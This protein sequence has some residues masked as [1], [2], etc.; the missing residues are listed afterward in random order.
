MQ[1]LIALLDRLKSATV[2]LQE[3][4]LLKIVENNKDT[5]IDLNLS[6]L[7]Q[8]RN[9]AG[10]SL[11]NYASKEYADFKRTLNPLG[12][13]DLKLEGD[14]HAGFYVEASK[15][16]VVIDSADEKTNELGIKYGED[17]FGLDQKNQAIFQAEIL[18]ETI[19]YYEELMGV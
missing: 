8:G 17:I 6:Q 13:I 7:M 9:S 11:G 5:L 4:D 14:F 3:K 12:V 15:F 16:P 1:D 19:K 2:E 18:L 10:Q